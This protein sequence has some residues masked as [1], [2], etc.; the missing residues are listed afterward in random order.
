MNPFRHSNSLA[1][2]WTEALETAKNHSLTHVELVAEW[3][4]LVAERDRLNRIGF[5]A[6][7][8]AD[9]RP[10]KRSPRPSQPGYV[11]KWA[12]PEEK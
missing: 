9:F 3:T 7:T 12:K 8:P 1:R 6:A 10:P 4:R 2:L 5:R 11:P